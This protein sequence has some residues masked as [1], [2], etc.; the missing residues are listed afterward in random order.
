MRKKEI[1]KKLKQGK[2]SEIDPHTLISI[3]ICPDCYSRLLNIQ[4]CKECKSCGFSV[5]D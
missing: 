4:G 5:C 3:N 1:M 2:H